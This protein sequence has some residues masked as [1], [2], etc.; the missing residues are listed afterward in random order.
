MGVPSVRAL[1]VEL[2]D[3]RGN[4][5]ARSSEAKNVS[6]V[7]A[8]AEVRGA[9]RARVRVFKGYGAVGLQVFTGS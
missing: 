5:V 4:L 2:Y 6:Q 9:W 3:Q 8:C 7:R 1:E